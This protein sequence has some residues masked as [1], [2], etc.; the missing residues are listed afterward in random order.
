[1]F[2]AVSKNETPKTGVTGVFGVLEIIEISPEIDVFL[3][4]FSTNC[5]F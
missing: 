5:G 4:N 2:G 3:K 1:V